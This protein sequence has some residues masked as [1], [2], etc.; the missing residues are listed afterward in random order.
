ML[1]AK[2]VTYVVEAAQSFWGLDTLFI[3]IAIIVAVIMPIYV[4]R[5]THEKQK[6]HE[7]EKD[8]K[9]RANLLES[10]RNDLFFVIRESAFLVG[11]ENNPVL[12]ERSVTAPLLSSCINNAP[13]YI[14]DDLPLL[15]RIYRFILRL[16]EL[17]A[18]HLAHI[19][20]TVKRSDCDY[21]RNKVALSKDVSFFAK[22]VI[23][24]IY[25]SLKSLSMPISMELYKKHFQSLG[26]GFV[27]Y[28]KRNSII[29]EIWSEE[30]E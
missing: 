25:S 11:E 19:R 26:V 16:N 12:E 10:I 2:T 4:L 22:K 27:L 8:E 15:L 14:A 17:H 7:K 24:L 18:K 23:S 5:K 21:N 1:Y 30:D 29:Q 28:G 20:D 3:M 9:R 6:Q 13:S